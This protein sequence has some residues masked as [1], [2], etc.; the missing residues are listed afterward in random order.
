MRASFGPRDCACRIPDVE[1][2]S[3]PSGVDRRGAG[4][5]RHQSGAVTPRPTCGLEAELSDPSVV[6][7]DGS[8]VALG[9]L[10]SRL[11]RLLSCV[12]AARDAFRGSG[13]LVVVDSGL[14]HQLEEHDRLRLEGLCQR[15]QIQQA[16]ADVGGGGDPVILGIATAR[17]AAVVS[18]DRFVEHRQR[19]PWLLEEDRLLAFVDA[20][21]GVWNFHTR[22]LLRRGHPQKTWTGTA[23][24]SATPRPQPSTSIEDRAAGA[25]KG[26]APTSPE[27]AIEKC[28]Q[29]LAWLLTDEVALGALEGGG[30]LM[31]RVG[32]IVH[33]A[34]PGLQVGQ[35]G[36]GRMT[37]LI[38]KSINGL[39][40]AVSVVGEHPALVKVA[41]GTTDDGAVRS[42]TAT[43]DAPE[44]SPTRNAT[45]G[46]VRDPLKRALETSPA[47]LALVDAPTMALA[48]AHVLS[49]PP[50]ATRRE[51]YHELLRRLPG[52]HNHR[53]N[54]LLSRFERVGVLTETNPGEFLVHSVISVAAAV[55][56]AM[57]T[58]LDDFRRAVAGLE[59]AT[60]DAALRAALEWR[61]P[62]LLTRQESATS[63]VPVTT[64]KKT[65]AKKTR[66]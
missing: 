24:P 43:L 19:F 36:F 62:L 4:N 8:N 38:E 9:A 3:A 54:G 66:R 21:R 10:T 58:V 29:V 26:E 52:I 47:G 20:G 17:A 61:A 13:V 45:P 15:G 41:A 39:P 50:L 18:N 49:S 48:A 7:I 46:P 27:H 53:A 42:N 5:F 64:A 51:L 40:V 11:D 32:A 25:I 30:V 31:A 23:K 63:S 22:D 57:E 33:K 35:L 60:D 12:A 28:H 2:E 65:A 44:P 59:G 37:N 55:D 1:A 14:R 56:A 16:P 34:L 6:V